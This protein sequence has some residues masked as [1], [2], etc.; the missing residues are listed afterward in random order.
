MRA[1]FLERDGVINA[2]R[3]DHV[4]CWQEFAFLPGALGALRALHLAGFY[5]FVVTNQAIISRGMASAQIIEEIHERMV[6]QVALCGGYIHDIRYCPHDRADICGCRKPQPGMLQALAAKWQVDPR[7]A[8]MVGD[9]WTDIAAGQTVGCRTIMV[10]TGRGAEQITELEA[11]QC[12]ADH[13]AA[14]LASAVDWLFQEE[15]LILPAIEEHPWPRRP[16]L[17]HQVA[18]LP[19]G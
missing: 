8:Y 13:V 14:D 10:R 9:A 6:L 3:I 11:H 4:T 7:Q 2:N 16:I 5:V 18:A 19:I 15:G 12:A 17:R 1:I